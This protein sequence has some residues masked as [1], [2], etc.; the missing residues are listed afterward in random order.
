M[1]RIAKVTDALSDDAQRLMTA[2]FIASRPAAAIAQM[3]WDELGVRVTVRT[4]SRRASEW[5]AERDRRA[6]AKE[7]MEDLVGALRGGNAEA[8][9]MIQA[10]A[11]ETLQNDPDALT[12]ADPVKLQTLAIQAEELRL[13]RKQL[14][15]RGRGMAINE[16]KLEMLEAREKRAREVLEGEK[17]EA[18]TAEERVQRIREIYGL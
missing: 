10:L 16:R 9:E 4:V 14:D 2:G 6:R 3:L 18:M 11:M 7:R 12:S 13:K 15:I 1:G 8:S 5:R 17:G